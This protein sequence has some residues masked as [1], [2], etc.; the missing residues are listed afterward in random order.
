MFFDRY[1][2][3]VKKLRNFLYIIYIDTDFFLYIKVEREAEN[4]SMDF[5]DSETSVCNLCYSLIKISFC[6][7]NNL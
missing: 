1:F 5:G 2:E 7:L 3:G 6:N 4:F